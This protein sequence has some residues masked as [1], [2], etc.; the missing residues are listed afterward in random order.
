MSNIFDLEDDPTI[1]GVSECKVPGI[2]Y[3]VVSNGNSGFSKIRV[4]WLQDFR[5]D[6]S[7]VGETENHAD[8]HVAFFAEKASQ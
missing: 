8:K 3:Y 1:S 5:D 7:W 6:Y 4:R 2:D